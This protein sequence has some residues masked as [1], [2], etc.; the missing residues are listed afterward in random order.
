MTTLSL[1]IRHIL[2]VVDMTRRNEFVIFDRELFVSK[3]DKLYLRFNDIDYL[4]PDS[5]ESLSQ[6]SDGRIWYK[7]GGETY[8]IFL[9]DASRAV[10]GINAVGTP[11]F[12]TNVTHQVLFGEI[13]CTITGMATSLVRLEECTF[14]YRQYAPSSP[15]LPVT[16]ADLTF[17]VSK[18][19]SCVQTIVVRAIAPDGITKSPE[20]TMQV[21]SAVSTVPS[22]V[23]FFSIPSPQE[24]SLVTYSL[25]EE[26]FPANI[27]C[28]GH[29]AYVGIS[30][31]PY[32]GDGTDWIN[33][34]N[35]SSNTAFTSVNNLP[36][37]LPGYCALRLEEGFSDSVSSFPQI[38]IGNVSNA[39]TGFIFKVRIVP[40]D[41]SEFVGNSADLMYA[42]SILVSNSDGAPILA[43]INLIHNGVGVSAST[44]FNESTSYTQF[45]FTGLDTVNNNYSV[46]PSTTNPTSNA[47]NFQ[48]TMPNVVG[49]L[50][51]PHTFRLQGTNKISGLS[52]FRDYPFLVKN[53]AVVDIN[54]PS[55]AVTVL[56]AST[57]SGDP[58][59]FEIAFKLSG[60]TTESGNKA[61]KLTGMSTSQMTSFLNVTKNYYLSGS[62]LASIGT[63]VISPDDIIVIRWNTT[64]FDT[65]N[66]SGSFT[67]TLSDPTYSYLGSSS[68]THTFTGYTELHV[69]GFLENPDITTLRLDGLVQPA[70]NY[71]REGDNGM[72]FTRNSSYPL[73]AGVTWK[74]ITVVPYNS[75]EVQGDAVAVGLAEVGNYTLPQILER[76]APTNYFGDDGVDQSISLDNLTFYGNTR[77]V[78]YLS[79]KVE[80]SIPTTNQKFQVDTG[81]YVLNDWDNTINDLMADDST[82]NIYKQSLMVQLN[83]LVFPTCSNTGFPSYWGQSTPLT[84][85]NDGVKDYFSVTSM[86]KIRIA[87]WEDS[88]TFTQV[89][90]PTSY[91][92]RLVAPTSY[93]LGNPLNVTTNL[94]YNVIDSAVAN[95]D[96][97]D[98]YSIPHNQ[99]ISLTL[100][101]PKS[102]F[103]DH[104]ERKTLPVAFYVKESYEYLDQTPSSLPRAYMFFMNIPNPY[105]DILLPDE[106]STS[107]DIRLESDNSIPPSF[108]Y[109]GINPSTGNYQYE[110]NE[111]SIYSALVSLTS[112]PPWCDSGGYSYSDEYQL[113]SATTSWISTDGSGFNLPRTESSSLLNLVWSRTYNLNSIIYQSTEVN[114][115]SRTFEIIPVDTNPP[116]VVIDDMGLS[117]G[118]FFSDDPAIK[119]YATGTLVGISNSV[120]PTVYDFSNGSVPAGKPSAPVHAWSGHTVRIKPIEVAG[121]GRIFGGGSTTAEEIEPAQTLYKTMIEFRNPNGSAISNHVNPYGFKVTE[122]PGSRTQTNGAFHVFQYVPTPALATPKRVIIRVYYF[123]PNA[124]LDAVTGLPDD[125]SDYK[126]IDFPITLS[127]KVW[128]IN[129][130][131][132]TSNDALPNVLNIGTDYSNITLSTKINC[133]LIDSEWTTNKSI[134]V[135]PNP[136][137]IYDLVSTLNTTYP[138]TNGV[139][140]MTSRLINCS[141]SWFTRHGISIPYPSSAHNSDLDEWNDGLTHTGSFDLISGSVEYEGNTY[142]FDQDN[143]VS[144]DWAYIPTVIGNYSWVAATPPADNR[145]LFAED[146]S[147]YERLPFSSAL[148]AYTFNAAKTKN[149]F[150]EG[151][152][153]RLTTG[154]SN[155]FGN[156]NCYISGDVY[157]SV[158]TTGTGYYTGTAADANAASVLY[159]K[160]KDQNNNTVVF[161]AGDA[162]YPVEIFNYIT[163]GKEWTADASAKIVRVPWSITQNLS[164]SDQFKFTPEEFAISVSV[165]SSYTTL[166]ASTRK[167]TET[168]IFY[169]TPPAADGYKLLSQSAFATYNTEPKLGT[170]A[171]QLYRLN[172]VDN[173]LV[174]STIK[175]SA[176]ASYDTNLKFEFDAA[177]GMTAVM[178]AGLKYHERK[179]K[180]LLNDTYYKVRPLFDSTIFQSTQ[181]RQSQLSVEWNYFIRGDDCIVLESVNPPQASSDFTGG[182]TVYLPRSTYL[183]SS[184]DVDDPYIRPVAASLVIYP[185]MTQSTFGTPSTIKNKA[186][187]VVV[188]ANYSK[189]FPFATGTTGFL[190]FS[191]LPIAISLDPTVAPY[192]NVQ[193]SGSGIL[194]FGSTT[195]K[196]VVA[197]TIEAYPAMTYYDLHA[198]TRYF[199]HILNTTATYAGVDLLIPVHGLMDLMYCDT[200]HFQT[201]FAP[202][203][204]GYRVDDPFT[205]TGLGGASH[206]H[207]WYNTV[208][209]SDATTGSWNGQTTYTNFSS[210]AKLRAGFIPGTISL[211]DG[212]SSSLVYDNIES[213][214]NLQFTTPNNVLYTLPESNQMHFFGNGAS[215]DFASIAFDILYSFFYL[216]SRTSNANPIKMT[217]LTLAVTPSLTTASPSA[218]FLSIYK[219]QSRFSVNPQTSGLLTMDAIYGIPSNIK[220]HLSL[221]SLNFNL[222]TGAASMQ[223]GYTT[224]SFS[225]LDSEAEFD[226]AFGRRLFSSVDEVTQDSTYYH[227]F[228]PLSIDTVLHK[229]SSAGYGTGDIS[230]DV[231]AVLTSTY[232]FL[233]YVEKPADST[234]RLATLI[235]SQYPDIT[236]A[237][238]E[239]LFIQFPY[240]GS[241]RDIQL[242]SDPVFKAIRITGSNKFILVAVVGG[243]VYMWAFTLSINVGTNVTLYS[244]INNLNYLGSYD[245]WEN[246]LGSS[247]YKNMMQVDEASDKMYIR[248]SITKVSDRYVD[249]DSFLVTVH[250]F[251]TGVES[252][253]PRIP[254]SYRKVFRIPFDFSVSD[255]G[256]GNTGAPVGM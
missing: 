51:A 19:S 153:I 232:A 199:G 243:T 205:S 196:Q 180:H 78:V 248:N 37:I 136:N 71:F 154:S 87:N 109:I 70:Q 73:P 100:R 65:T 123:H 33:F 244:A 160:G 104:P 207:L 173:S 231:S 188:T 236:A 143:T 21:K 108:Q 36:S 251:S 254:R 134:I 99:V 228:I 253:Y 135:R 42:S 60:G 89:K 234:R 76:G 203:S 1:S 61:Y 86:F 183:R 125:G 54:V 212:M 93:N 200:K 204:D 164:A 127:D 152:E 148:N 94:A 214:W 31:M 95:R 159:V 72:I 88:S 5:N 35:S 151:E 241:F 167:I 80:V 225:Q 30:H 13:I 194:W 115:V 105:A 63:H 246:Y 97:L 52:S 75:I 210:N 59:K 113:L 46:V 79:V 8:E 126:W 131:N 150:T 165:Y 172:T 227:R 3:D 140:L 69:N 198:N 29:K 25:N 128:F 179:F 111:G 163:Q 230:K 62:G 192:M 41:P 249:I 34:Y 235:L 144:F 229:T 15:W 138:I 156:A 206:L 224:S 103:V 213:K 139:Y 178:P 189:A 219:I 83:D 255:N 67:I 161:T 137:Y 245:L 247:V 216:S 106:S 49:S 16:N 174:A 162:N 44:Q 186:C 117:V 145:S 58:T 74:I 119:T 47:S 118:W 50:T 201:A 250:N 114:T 222:A 6:D 197:S 48:C 14:E 190:D 181:G 238:D 9:P 12:T 82:D 10:T 53:L 242:K 102:E 107:L 11:I 202:T 149:Y 121:G 7:L 218:N 182:Y 221:A 155:T 129:H 146:V 168:I 195:K 85:S 26:V 141:G 239:P 20:A 32:G 211:F 176:S 240:T 169:I 120:N 177:F 24:R 98:F 55:F 252:T 43:G 133:T 193:T 56:S 38:K 191:Y 157:N 39:G 223:L 130:E 217:P 101:I 45:A 23:S 124:S 256:G 187:L 175:S 132:G 77:W 28:S 112:N 185:E 215:I 2:P 96:F 147:P 92:G 220:S 158:L 66:S 142:F 208:A 84:P 4:I 57:V 209:A 226:K 233:H 122:D 68:R 27:F 64:L 90:T 18:I 17:T 81:L 237:S 110:L 91:A 116:P 170:V 40:N 184:T 22:L 166:N 171:R